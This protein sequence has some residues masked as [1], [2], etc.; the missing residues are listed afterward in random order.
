MEYFSYQVC[1]YFILIQEIF[2]SQLSKWKPSSQSW[3]WSQR[4]YPTAASGSAA[5]HQDVQNPRMLPKNAALSGVVS[6]VSQQYRIYYSSK[7]CP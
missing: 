4:P 7:C 3:F 2:L 5:D 1:N 6:Y